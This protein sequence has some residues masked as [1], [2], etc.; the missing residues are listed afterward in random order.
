MLQRAEQAHQD[1]VRLEQGEL[2]GSVL[3][4]QRRPDLG[5]QIGRIF[6]LPVRAW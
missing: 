2:V 6:E 3:A 5:D 1:G 4:A